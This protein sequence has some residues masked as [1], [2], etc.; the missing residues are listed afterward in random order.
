MSHSVA[1]GLGTPE[2]NDAQSLIG[3]W[4]DQK[5]LRMAKAACWAGS[6]S[7]WRRSRICDATGIPAGSGISLRS[8]RETKSEW[9]EDCIAALSETDSAVVVLHDIPGA[10]VARLPEFLTRIEE[11]GINIVR[12]F[13]DS[14]V[15]TRNGRFVTVPQEIVAA[16]VPK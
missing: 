5:R 12:E 13:P 15:V 2:I 8:T 4:P 9:V 14:V 16:R 6:C 1:F 7:A 11:R 3:I 10:C